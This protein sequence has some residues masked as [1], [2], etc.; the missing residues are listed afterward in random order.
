MADITNLTQFLTDVATAIKQKT[1]KEEKIPAENFDT[2]IL[3]I[4]S[5]DDN[6]HLYE[7]VEE[8]N[9]DTKPNAQAVG[10]VAKK[11]NLRPIVENSQAKCIYCPKTIVLPKR[12]SYYNPETSQWH[13][14]GGL[15][16]REDG[17]LS[18]EIEEESGMGG[19]SIDYDT[20]DGLTY[21]RDHEPDISFSTYSGTRILVDDV[22]YLN[23]DYYISYHLE[24][25]DATEEDKELLRL[26]VQQPSYD[27]TGI[28]SYEPCEPDN[29]YIQ[30]FSNVKV[31][32]NHPEQSWISSQYDCTYDISPELVKYSDFSALIAKIKSTMPKCY[33]VI[34]EFLQD[35][36]DGYK[37]RTYCYGN[38]DNNYYAPSILHVGDVTGIEDDGLY[39]GYDYYD[40]PFKVFAFTE[41]FTMTDCSDQFVKK[42]ATCKEGSN[43]RNYYYYTEVDLSTSTNWFTYIA[44]SKNID[45][46]ASISFKFMGDGWSSEGKGNQHYLY[47]CVGYKYGYMPMSS[48]LSLYQGDEL[49]EGHSAL[50]S[51]GIINGTM[52]NNGSVTI[53]PSDKQQTIP[54]GYHN[55]QGKVLPITST[56]KLDFNTPSVDKPKTVEYGFSKSG[57]YYVPDG[58]PLNKDSYCI[59]YFTL[60][61][62]QN[63]TFEYV[64]YTEDY[65]Y[66]MFS[67][68]DRK[69]STAHNNTT[70]NVY[71]NC[72]YENDKS[73]K[74]LVYNN[75]S[76]GTHFIT[77]KI[78]SNTWSSNIG[79][80][81]FKI[82]SNTIVD[83]NITI[84][85]NVLA[86]KTL[87]DLQAYENPIV[88][89]LAVVFDNENNYLYMYDGEW[90]DVTNRIMTLSEYDELCDLASSILDEKEV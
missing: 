17:M 9:A 79:T 42:T 2:E 39:F 45:D 10:V 52:S 84:S 38:N 44:T 63:V 35:D 4:Q 29:D 27:L 78:H 15:R 36:T 6:I 89:D 23:G 16:Y 33:S 80:D 61:Q 69:L 37:Y 12:L 90:T 51:T 14:Y 21:T 46:Y 62:Q 1:G 87:A 66:M 82:K 28:Y 70:L 30:K 73:V 55:G 67:E 65:S 19:L 60:S 32:K 75:V 77:V 81:I 20:E 25:T 71:K 43:T 56:V 18:I 47:V 31:T 40:K 22:M 53:T 54:K 8:M 88:N 86:F 49:L 76:V 72:H 85:Y 83:G 59:I 13:Y 58:S 41:D 24:N 48:Q 11:Y 50:G 57:D 7:T 34:L 5:G 68:L 64:N 74:T 3:N 26:F